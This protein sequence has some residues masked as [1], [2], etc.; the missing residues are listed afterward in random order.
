MKIIQINLNH[1]EA[2][3][4]LLMQTIN[5]LKV[6]LAIISEQ[7]K[8]LESTTWEADATGRA[9]IWSCWD[10][11][12]QERM[13][14]SE[15]GF[16]RVKIRGIYIYS[17]YAPPNT[18]IEEFKNFL[19][20]LVRDAM[21]RRAV[22]IAG[23]FNA[24]AVEWGCPETN[25]RGE[26]LL[27][28][29]SLLDVVLLNSGRTHTFRRAGT[30]S[31]VDVT[32]VS[33]SLITAAKN[34]KVSEQYTHSDHQAILWELSSGDIHQNPKSTSR[35]KATGWKASAFDEATFQLT[36]E[37]FTIQ[38]DTAVGKVD[39]VMQH[40]AM[41]C[42]ASMPRKSINKNRHPVYWWND[43]IAQLRRDCH[44]TRRLYQRSRGKANYDTLQKKHKDA[45]A[46]LKK[47]IKI[48]KRCCWQ[49]LCSQIDRDP[50]G[51]P[52]RVVMKKLKGYPMA[53]PTCPN[54]LKKIVTELFPQQPEH[55]HCSLPSTEEMS[56]PP[57]TREE[58]IKACNRVKTRKAPGLDGIPNVALKSAVIAR[59]DVFVDMYNACLSESVFP[60][61]WK[62]QR[63]VL[64]PKG[65]K[66]PNEPSS[67]RPLCMLD[68]AGKLLERIICDRT[69]EALITDGDLAENQYGFRKS[70]STV[71]AVNLVIDTAR[72][73]ISGKRW[74][75][76]TKK[77]CLVATLDIKNAFNSARWECIGN[78]LNKRN[79]PVYLKK[80]IANYLSNRLLRYDTELGP[81]EHKVTGGVPQGSVLGPL[82]W[83]IMYD[84][85]LKLPLPQE[86]RLVAFADDVAVVIV[87][88]YLE[89]I[90]NIFNEVMK[91]VQRWM[92]KVGL[93]LAAHKTEAVLITGRKVRETITLTVGRNSITSQPYIRYL[94]ILIDARLTFKDHISF[95][96]DKAAAISSALSRLMPNIGG[97]KQS[98]RL[99]LTTVMS[100][101][102]LYGAPVWTESLDVQLYRK[103][104]AA[105]YRRAALRVTCA[106]RTVSDDA[107]LVIA[108]MPPID[109]LSSE[110]HRLYH[111]KTNEAKTKIRKQERNKSMVQWQ[112]RWDR[113][114]KG[115]W[116]HCII[117]NIEEWHNSCN[118]EVNYYLTQLISG[119]GCFRS[120]LYKYKWED[121]PE[122]P[123]CQGV[124]EN[125][126]HVT[127][128]C[129]RFDDARG[130]LQATVGQVLT[131]HELGKCMLASV[132]G[133]KAVTAFATSIMKE[134]RN[135]EQE[136]KNLSLNVGL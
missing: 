85:L 31:I 79:I 17:C 98:R 46:M 134:L 23:D 47:A 34:W 72:Q 131:P 13:D 126:E 15:S 54:L 35:S 78:A 7:Y 97:P 24:W 11:S 80:L 128:Q 6:N 52:Y 119:H 29:I 25:N 83:N 42:D 57:V 67:Y 26:A 18:Q 58:V 87:A 76:G 69:Q 1:C 92:D 41:A 36:M 38:C 61:R 93:E 49:E 132:E 50:W 125:A 9:A 63:L 102:L 109:I 10:L 100:S 123:R 5:E 48:S 4:D 118:G 40:I 20:R 89:E 124:T 127:F 64:I 73:A 56:V 32:F 117:P 75:R 84:G 107:I 59:P 90:S 22:V 71:D 112:K 91:I 55:Q 88:K 105:V 136:R 60:D 86:A 81:R 12:L 68:T 65:K 130:R 110:R 16:V 99:L 19:D 82:L 116:T 103:K 115:R 135:Q 14:K 8:N 28:A 108:K 27:E 3:Q 53:A 133:W 106:F 74:K 114:T 33:S 94:G 77:Y 121:S 101:I 44:K 39:D 51:K 21:G 111:N 96:T 104:M 30:G 62:L 45:R 37:N 95:A 113:S 43:N 122:C 2:A 66:P 129:P 70:R 120:Y